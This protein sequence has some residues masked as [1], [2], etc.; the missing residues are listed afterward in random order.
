MTILL[1]FHDDEDPLPISSDS[2]PK[3]PETAVDIREPRTFHRTI[4]DGEL[5][6][7]S[8]NSREAA[9]DES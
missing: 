9:R 7:K 5:L 2:A 3:H 4:E 8:E 6:P 1:G